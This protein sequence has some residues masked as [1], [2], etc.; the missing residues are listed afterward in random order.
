LWGTD[1]PKAM[2]DI[3]ESL[4]GAAHADGGFEV[5]QHAVYHSLRT[6]LNAVEDA[7]SA[8]LEKY[9]RHPKRNVLSELGCLVSLENVIEENLAATLPNLLFWAGD[10][11]GTPDPSGS[12]LVS[13]LKCFG[14]PILAVADS[15]S[16][17]AVNRVCAFVLSF[18]FENKSYLAR[19]QN[20]KANV[21][22]SLTVELKKE[23]QLEIINGNTN[24]DDDDG[25]DLL[26]IPD[27]LV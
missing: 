4:F 26:A 24:D 3:V 20:L 8:D 16:T 19:F 6:I 5:G 27:V 23:E 11:W 18:L 17:S 2:A 1:P 22:R 13:I 7:T 12:K 10:H 25:Q 9:C 14:E 15:V 21:Q